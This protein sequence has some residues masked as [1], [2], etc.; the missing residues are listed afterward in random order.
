[1]RFQ[2]YLRLGFAAALFGCAF[3][4]PA[5][6]HDGPL[7][8]LG[9]SQGQWPGLSTLN[10]PE[11]APPPTPL[12]PFDLYDVVYTFKS[13]ARYAE[14]IS[15]HRYLTE[16]PGFT[17]IST[18]ELGQG[19]QIGLRVLEAPSVWD[20]SHF[21]PTDATFRVTGTTPEYKSTDFVVPHGAMDAAENFW[22]ID[23]TLETPSHGHLAF[24]L[25]GD[26]QN[27]VAGAD[28]IYKLT[29]EVWQT[30]AEL[31]GAKFESV[32]PFSILFQIDR[33]A[34]DDAD[35]P[36]PFPHGDADLDAAFAMT[37]SIARADVIARARL[38]AVPEP[39]GLALLALGAALLRRRRK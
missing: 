12:P 2:T 17:P 23:N 18:S 19:D 6:A 7:V 4:R 31:D 37:D 20:G 10:G 8:Y 36:T 35:Q 1:M 25:L 11:V 13:P 5:S 15:A 26:G 21:V 33:W 27:F 34:E 16:F 39:S 22:R 29:A 28:G 9:T 32:E 14:S 30:P 24:Y 38:A 3:A